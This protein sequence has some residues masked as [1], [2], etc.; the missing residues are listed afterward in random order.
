MSKIAVVC[1]TNS[2]EIKKLY[3]LIV[4]CKLLIKRNLIVLCRQKSFYEVFSC[5]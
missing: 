4:Q 3:Y 1:L 5:K 2:S